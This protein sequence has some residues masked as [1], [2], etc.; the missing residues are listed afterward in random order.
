MPSSYEFWMT[1]D[2]GRK[3]LLL[4]DYAFFSYSRTTNG[5]GTMQIGLPYA[6]IKNKVTPVFRRDRRIDVWR[7]PGAGIPAR[8]EGMYILFGYRIYTRQTD[9]V[10]MV[11]F[12]ANTAK[13]MLSRRVVLQPDGSEATYK[14]GAIDDLMKRIVREQFLYGSVLDANGTAIDNDRAFPEGE[15]SVQADLGLG[16]DIAIQFANRKVLDVLKELKDASFQLNTLDYLTYQKIYFDVIPV[17][18]GHGF[19]EILD[20]NGQPITDE[21]GQ[22]LLDEQSATVIKEGAVGLQ[23][24]TYAG[25]YGKDRTADIVF[26]IENN[27]ILAPEYYENHNT[28]E[29]TIVV[30]GYGRGDSRPYIAVQ[31]TDRAKA[32]RWS[33]DESYLDASQEPDQDNLADY[34]YSELYLKKPIESINC[35]FLSI[36]GSADTPQS[37]YGID[38]D[39]GDLLL[40]QYADRS[41]TVEVEIV[42]VSVDETG[43]E[44]IE[45]KNTLETVT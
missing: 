3:I 2:S 43:D 21:F 18:L 22:H 42:Y 13:D 30:K 10:T 24:V 23:F 7:S 33:R 37:L 35:T 32:S 29:N 36:E 28:S 15:F 5:V 8:R 1:D 17:D 41:F 9:N 25:L 31:D 39:L 34:G 40:V 26:S 16:P 12:Y 20:E 44:N 27:N 6:S 11:V 19:D 4:Q 45:G 14:T 38:W